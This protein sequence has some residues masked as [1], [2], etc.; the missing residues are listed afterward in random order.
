M[1]VKHIGIIAEDDS[2]IEVLKILTRKLTNC[3]FATSH[4]VGKGCG[5][6]KRKTP[7]WCKAL[8]LKGCESVVLV[9]DLDKNN[10]VKLR[11]QLE[12][13]I[14]AVKI[15]NK[16]V[17]IPS[18]ELEAWLLS[19]ANALKN[20]MNL[21]KLPKKIFHPETVVSPKEHI[22]EIVRKHSKE[23]SKR[24]VNTVH[25]KLIAEQIDIAKVSKACPSFNQF[26][27][28]VSTAIG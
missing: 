20:A 24:Y 15:E 5:P 26:E 23:S 7:G 11:T 10:A 14:S 3:R 2:D 16:F 18:E 4:F 13:I 27:I 25:N 19:D 22:G 17:V 21:I 28:F 1:R 8:L 6:L 12:L 9:H